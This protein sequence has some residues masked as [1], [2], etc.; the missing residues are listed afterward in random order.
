MAGSIA[1]ITGLRQP[2]EQQGKLLALGGS[3]IL[4]NVEC[5]T[6][7]RGGKPFA[8]AIGEVEGVVSRN[9]YEIVM[10]CT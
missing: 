10:I 8:S 4:Q 7:N 6:V 9:I 2:K 1:E 3:Y 5:A